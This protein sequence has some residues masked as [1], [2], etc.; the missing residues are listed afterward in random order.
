MQASSQEE[1]LLRLAEARRRLESEIEAIRNKIQG[2]ELACQV[3]RGRVDALERPRAPRG[4][5]K[6]LMIGLLEEA[7]SDGLNA[8]T[9]VN[10]AAQQGL[11][12]DRNTA[13]SLLSR[14]K[15]YGVVH[16]DGDRYRLRERNTG[17]GSHAQ[18]AATA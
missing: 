15:R 14:L 3:L 11:D 8:V 16:H 4:N 10:L 5:V 17:G 18:L 2:I 7:G 13:S 6:A 9:A 12:L 1:M